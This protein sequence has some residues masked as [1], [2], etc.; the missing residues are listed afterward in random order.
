MLI[1]FFPV[2][3]TDWRSKSRMEVDPMEVLQIPAFIIIVHAF[4]RDADVQ[5]LMQ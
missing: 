3:S 4:K 5:D 2:M 1:T